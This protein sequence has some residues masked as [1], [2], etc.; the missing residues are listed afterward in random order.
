MGYTQGVLC[1]A[2][3]IEGTK[4]SDEMGFALI[5]AAQLGRDL[6]PVLFL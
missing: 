3:F 5:P 2:C 6:R 1:R 4:Y